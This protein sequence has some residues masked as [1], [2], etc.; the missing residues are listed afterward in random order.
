MRWLRKPSGDS[1]AVAMSSIKLGD[2]LLVVGSSD[3]S[4]IAT[5]ATRAGL[6][7]RTC[8]VDASQSVSAR[9]AGLVEREGALV[10]SFAAPYGSLPFEFNAFDVVV[11]RNV[12]GTMDVKEQGQLASEVRRVLRPGGRCIVIEGSGRSG[13]SAWFGGGDDAQGVPGKGVE[14]ILADAGFRGVRTL[15]QREGLLFIEGVKAGTG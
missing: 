2:R 12:L 11:I 15:A 6:T 7:G 10:E 9:S 1:L 4:L 14:Q 3:V 8:M 13:L 5:L